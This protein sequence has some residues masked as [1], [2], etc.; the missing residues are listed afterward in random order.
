MTV[1]AYLPFPHSISHPQLILSPQKLNLVLPL[2]PPVETLHDCYLTLKE[3][4]TDI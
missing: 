1:S 2:V 4:F 3:A